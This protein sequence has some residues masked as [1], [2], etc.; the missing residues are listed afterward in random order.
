MSTPVALN[1]ANQPAVDAVTLRLAV[2]ENAIH[3]AFILGGEL[4]KILKT[5]GETV[6]FSEVPDP[7]DPSYTAPP[8]TA[9]PAPQTGF[10]PIVYMETLEYLG[11]ALGALGEA[12]GRAAD[13]H[14]AV[15]YE[16]C[17]HGVIADGGS[18]K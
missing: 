17:K 16:Y 5:A 11:K 3:R 2:F 6:I 8:V 12:A 9:V 7:N 14:N 4:A 15:R 10:A 18:G 13:T 1:P